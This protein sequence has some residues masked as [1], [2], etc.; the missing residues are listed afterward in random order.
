MKTIRG[1]H[2]QLGS[3]GRNKVSFSYFDDKWYILNDGI[4]SYAYGH[5]KIQMYLLTKF[6]TRLVEKNHTIGS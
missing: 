1:D 4:Q 2:H 5:F 3:Y 6:Q